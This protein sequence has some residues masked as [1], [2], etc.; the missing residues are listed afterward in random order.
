MRPTSARASFRAG[1]PLLIATIAAA[2]PLTA[3]HGELPAV[4]GS[5]ST[6]LGA[7]GAD[8]LIAVA[9]AAPTRWQEL[10]DA[11][12]DAECP[13]YLPRSVDDDALARALLLEAVDAALAEPCD[14]AWI[15]ASRVPEA[16]SAAPWRDLLGA[17]LEHAP[18][19]P[20]DL[21]TRLVLAAG[22]VAAPIG[23]DVEWAA[24]PPG[25]AAAG[26]ATLALFH[27]AADEPDAN[28][29]GMPDRLADALARRTTPTASAPEC[30]DLNADGSV[31]AADLTILLAA[32]GTAGPGDLDGDG[33]VGAADLAVLLAAW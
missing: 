22:L 31:D 28:G 3:A 19:A 1:R 20:S 10:A 32:W 7:K 25:P 24:L 2:A 30:P 17:P 15:G 27:A 8:R 14:T 26:A 11:G 4:I 6:A 16:G 21:S 12:A 29:D 33:I 5:R 23:S 13:L 18:F 9:F